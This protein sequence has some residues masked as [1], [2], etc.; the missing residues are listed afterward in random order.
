MLKIDWNQVSYI[1]VDGKSHKVFHNGVL[2]KDRESFLPPT[3]RFEDVAF[4]SDCSERSEVEGG[5][6]WSDLLP[7]SCIASAYVGKT[8]SLFIPIEIKSSTKNYLFSFQ[9][10][11]LLQFLHDALNFSSCQQTL[12]N[13]VSH[14][15]KSS[16]EP[17][18]HG[19]LERYLM[20]PSAFFGKRLISSREM[21]KLSAIRDAGFPAS[22]LEMEISSKTGLLNRAK[23]FVGSLPTCS[24]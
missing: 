20:M 5:F 9:I 21:P 19:S 4:P 2:Y 16:N 12:C 3:A 14:T 18:V 6:L 24:T 10:K 11:A 23:N 17:G 8:F 7:Q 15:Y 1:D 22:H 13:R